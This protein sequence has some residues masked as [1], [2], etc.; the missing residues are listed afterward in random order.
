MIRETIVTTL[1]ADGGPH[2]APMGVHE[3]GDRLV[4]APFRPSRSLDNLA[5]ARSAVV[6]VTDDVRVF[7]GC[8]TGRRD[9]PLCATD[10]VQGVRL[11]DALGHTELA[12][13]RIEDDAVRPRFV[14]TAVHRATHRHFAG[15]NRAQ[16]A[17]IEAAILVSRLHLLP[18][19]KIEAEIAYLTIAVDKT[20]GP[21]EREAWTWLLE[22]IDAHRART[23]AQR[24]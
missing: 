5:R 10:V 11:R 21:N 22:A 8:L 19:D 7:A 17:V 1:A 24:A 16:Y 13:E 2:I 18:A 12:V 15:F 3:Q 14:C 9:W 20:A 23:R 4:L 6:N